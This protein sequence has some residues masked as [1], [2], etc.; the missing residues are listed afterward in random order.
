M[1]TQA[2]KLPKGIVKSK[3]QQIERDWNKPGKGRAPMKAPLGIPPNADISKNVSP[4]EPFRKVSNS[5]ETRWWWHGWRTLENRARDDY[6]MQY[7]ND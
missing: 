1:K 4:R 5:L 7:W 6:K 2:K 3:L